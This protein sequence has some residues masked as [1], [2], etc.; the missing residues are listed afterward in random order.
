V[1]EE[2]EQWD[3]EE[4]ATAAERG[5]QETDEKA[6]QDQRHDPPHGEGNGHFSRSTPLH[7]GKLLTYTEWT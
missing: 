2:R 1:E 4:T 5:H 6:G 7:N 3:V